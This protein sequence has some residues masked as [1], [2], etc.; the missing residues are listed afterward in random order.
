MSYENL[1]VIEAL[2]KIAEAVGEVNINFD[3]QTVLDALKTVD[4]AGSGLDAD[5]VDGLHAVDVNAMKVSKNSVAYYRN[6]AH[7]SSSGDPVTGTLK[8]TLPFLFPRSMIS[9]TI[10]GYDYSGGNDGKTWLVRTGGY[11]YRNGVWYHYFA[12]IEGPSPFSTVRLAND[13]SNNVILLGD[14][15]TDWRH[16][17]IVISDILVGYLNLDGWETGWNIEWITDESGIVNVFSPVVHR[18][19]NVSG[20][21]GGGEYLEIDVGNNASVLVS[22]NVYG[23]CSFLYTVSDTA[24]TYAG[25]GRVHTSLTNYTLWAPATGNVTLEMTNEAQIYLHNTTDYPVKVTLLLISSR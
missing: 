24:D 16:P 18:L 6:V 25:Q 9:V 17:K 4:G 21:G 2:A 1:A 22:D 20:G 15:N 8:I 7:L 5:T 12:R 3:A 10:R 14:I 13:G 11:A 19:D 23:A